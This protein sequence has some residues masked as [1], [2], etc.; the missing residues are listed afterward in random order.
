MKVTVNFS[1]VIEYQAEVD[2]DELVELT[3]DLPR[4][5]FDLPT[6]K[7]LED[8]SVYFLKDGKGLPSDELASY[9][10]DYSYEIDNGAVEVTDM[11]D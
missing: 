2:Y 1:Q 4:D 10:I 5:S 8:V 3:G 9:L 11:H 7:E 6:E